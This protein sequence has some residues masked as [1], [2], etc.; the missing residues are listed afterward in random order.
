M[1]PATWEEEELAAYEP[2][3][4]KFVEETRQAAAKAALLARQLP[5]QWKALREILMIRCESLN[6]KAGRTIL[7]PAAPDPDTLEIRREDDSKIVVHFEAAK[8]KVTFSGK[9]F[10]YDREYELIVPTFGA[11]D[12]TVWYNQSTLATDQPDDIAKTMLGVFLRAEES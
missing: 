8:K 2:K 3:R 12:T 5:H 11:A 9:A 10:G 4:A 1:V 7:R 6:A